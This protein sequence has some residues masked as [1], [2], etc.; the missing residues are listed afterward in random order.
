MRAVVGVDPGVQGGAVVLDPTGRAVLAWAAWHPVT[1]GWRVRVSRVAAPVEHTTLGDALSDALG[2]VPAVGALA[3]LE[4]LFIPTRKDGAGVLAPGEIGQLYEAAGRALALLEIRTSAPVARPSSAAWRARAWGSWGR[5]RGDA[6][7]AAL[8]LA[9]IL[10]DWSRA[11]LSP[12]LT[13][14]EREGVC[15]ALGIARWLD[16]TRRLEI[17]RRET[18]AD[19]LGRVP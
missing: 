14:D 6:K 19:L 7:A 2:V 5:T 15:E 17:A 12:D 3:A 10:A 9:P 11:P 13:A 16:T 8:R 1:H 4:D 18:D